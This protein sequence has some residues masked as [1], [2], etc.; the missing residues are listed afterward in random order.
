MITIY[1][2]YS[3]LYVSQAKLI[4]FFSKSYNV[5]WTTCILTV[6]YFKHRLTT[7][8]SIYWNQYWRYFNLKAFHIIQDGCIKK[9]YNK[10]KKKDACSNT[11]I[12]QSI[13][14]LRFVCVCIVKIAI[15]IF[16]NLSAKIIIVKAKQRLIFLIIHLR[17]RLLLMYFR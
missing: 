15:K 17:N 10:Y 13:F 16:F 4:L 9:L 3:N 14:T 7:H 2:F 12:K 6:I 5:L 1:V 8:V 11:I